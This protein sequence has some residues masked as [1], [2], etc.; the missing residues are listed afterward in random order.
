MSVATTRSAQRLWG[1]VAV[2][3]LFV[4]ASFAVTASGMAA[5]KSARES[6]PAGAHVLYWADPAFAVSGSRSTQVVVTNLSVI[7]RVRALINALPLS[8]PHRVCPDDMMIPVA[9]SFA[10]SRSA[11]PYSRVVFQLGGC[12]SAQVFQHG[13]GVL[14]TLGG[15]TLTSTFVAIRK[16]VDP[17]TTAAA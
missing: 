8:T 1:R 16:L 3:G 7:N 6:I 12:P 10:V 14:P 4:A 2:A 17:S 9:V 5:T 13:A 11:T 15:S